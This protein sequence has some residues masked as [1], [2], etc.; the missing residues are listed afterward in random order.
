MKVK[1]NIKPDEPTVNGHI[2]PK[3]IIEREILSRELPVYLGLGTGELN[4]LSDLI[5]FATS[6][7]NEN[8]EIVIE[9]KFLNTSEANVFKAMRPDDY[10]YT[11]KGLG[12][13]SKDKKIIDFKCS[14]INVV[15]KEG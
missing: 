13:A 15:D 12:K 1:L 7:L 4:D 10:E 11:I 14:S 6:K 9:I 5:G 3:D 8:N 2:Y